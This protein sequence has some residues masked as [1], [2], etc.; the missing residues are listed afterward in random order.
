MRQ[1]NLPHTPTASPAFTSPQVAP[2][3]PQS[4]SV[5][6]ASALSSYASPPHSD[7][8]WNADSG[9]SAHMTCHRLWIQNLRPHRVQI[10]LADGSVV[11]SEGVGSVRFNS[12]VN[13]REMAPLEFA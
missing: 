6:P 2:S 5:A 1:H 3:L 13:G 11:Y 4:A 12:V 8:S 9:A 7:S 10:R